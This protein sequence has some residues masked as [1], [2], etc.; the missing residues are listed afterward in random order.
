[1][2]AVETAARTLSIA[3]AEKLARALGTTLS[4]MLAELEHS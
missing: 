2:G 3:Q 1:V 4:A